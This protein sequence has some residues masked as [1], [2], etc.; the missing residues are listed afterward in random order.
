MLQP[1]SPSFSATHAV[2][3]ELLGTRAALF[4]LW[5]T[6]RCCPGFSA[7]TDARSDGAPGTRSEPLAPKRPAACLLEDTFVFR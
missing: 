2:P 6:A 3:A 7:V 4:H 1:L 5:G